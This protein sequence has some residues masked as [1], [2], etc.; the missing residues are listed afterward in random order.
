PYT[1]RALHLFACSPRSA[2]S[3]RFLCVAPALC[4]RLPSDL[5]SPGEPLPSA[6]TSPYRACRGLSPPSRCALPGAQKKAA[7]LFGLRLF[8]LRAWRCPTLTWGDPT[9][10]SALSVFT[11]E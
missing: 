6:N 3:I 11:S 4:F 7:T 10:P 1:Y 8:A 9:L 5:R 2:A